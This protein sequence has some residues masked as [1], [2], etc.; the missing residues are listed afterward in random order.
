MSRDAVLA[1]AWAK[2][3]VHPNIHP[4]SSIKMGAFFMSKITQNAAVTAK[5]TRFMTTKTLAYCALLTAIQVVLARLIVPMP[6]ADVRFSIEAVPVFL[7]GMLFGPMAGGLVGFAADLCGC[8]FSGYGY[9]PLFCVPPILYGVCGGLFR[10]Y[11]ARKSSY[12]RF[13]LTLLP[14]VIAGSVLYQSL[15]LT[16]VYGKGGAFLANLLPRL[17]ARSLQFTVTIVVEALVL[18][19]LFRSKLFQRLCVWPVQPKRREVN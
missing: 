10:Y 12:V 8:L 14:P 16:Y 7:A 13:L 11:L 6:A 18:D 5:P 19:L 2:G 1:T 9:N 4:T 3:V 15:A 17:G